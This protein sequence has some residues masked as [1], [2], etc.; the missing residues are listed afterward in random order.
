MNGNIEVKGHPDVVGDHL[1]PETEY[2]ENSG[3]RQR[4][5]TEKGK[6]YKISCW[7]VEN[8][9]CT[10]KSWE[11]VVLSTIFYALRIIW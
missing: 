4:Q 2:E 8:K 11:N 10:I 9:G 1:L 7:E 3:Q 5:L 6:E